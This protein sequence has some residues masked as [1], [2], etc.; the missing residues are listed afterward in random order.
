MPNNLHGNPIDY[1]YATPIYDSLHGP[2][3]DPDYVYGQRES[4]FVPI[5]GEMDWVRRIS[6]PNSS[7]T[8]RVRCTR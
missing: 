1:S 7:T 4:N 2:M 5:D 8:V 3:V 6:T